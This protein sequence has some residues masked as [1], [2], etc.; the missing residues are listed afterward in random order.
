M[1]L[2]FIR[3]GEKVD[4]SFY[5]EDAL[6]LSSGFISGRDMKPFIENFEIVSVGETKVLIP[7]DDNYYR[8]LYGES[9]KTPKIGRKNH[10]NYGN[11]IEKKI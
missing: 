5:F 2:C 9:W 3:K 4:V 1:M 6:K 7:S 11:Q 10:S 8:A